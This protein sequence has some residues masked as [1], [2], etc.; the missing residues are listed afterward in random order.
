MFGC[1]LVAIIE[2]LEL[3]EWAVVLVSR[4]IKEVGFG[5]DGEFGLVNDPIGYFVF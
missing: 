1:C 5:R 4:V 2:C 3:D